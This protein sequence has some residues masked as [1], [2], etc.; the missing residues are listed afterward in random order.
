MCETQVGLQFTN[1]SMNLCSY[2][3]YTIPKS[4]SQ[5]NKIKYIYQWA[6]PS[7]TTDE[8]ATLSNQDGLATYNM[9]G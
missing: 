6:D 4:M 1:A 2:D 5:T 9:Y 7:Y 8:Q 3:A